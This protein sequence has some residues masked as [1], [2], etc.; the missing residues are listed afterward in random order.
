VKIKLLSVAVMIAFCAPFL[1]GVQL[2]QYTFEGAGSPVVLPSSVAAALNAS[3]L[4]LVNAGTLSFPAG[5][6]SA[7]FGPQGFAAAGNNWTGVKD[8]HYFSFTITPVD[9]FAVSLSSLSFASLKEGFLSVPSSKVW[10]SVG[11]A[12]PIFAGEMPGVPVSS[13]F[14]AP[15][16]I[17]YGGNLLLRTTPISS[18]IEIRISQNGMSSGARFAI[19]N[20]T[21]NGT[22]YMRP[23]SAVPEPATLWSIAA[24]SALVGAVSVNR[25]RR[26]TR[27]S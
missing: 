17:F 6:A 13:S 21:L 18:P 8:D 3:P 12:L 9:G 10:Y 23:P 26:A 24:F 7:L 5:S 25:I 1:R 19:D 27:K 16:G 22:V 4:T 15:G 2:V 11:G 14:S 20:V